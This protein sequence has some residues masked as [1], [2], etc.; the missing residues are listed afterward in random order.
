MNFDLTVMTREQLDFLAMEIEKE[1]NKRQE[2]LREELITAFRKAY[3]DLHK[4]FIDVLV[5][6]EIINCFE[7][8][9]FY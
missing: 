3:D 7:E 4:N 1:R 6:D 5:N 9:D 8:F 2:K